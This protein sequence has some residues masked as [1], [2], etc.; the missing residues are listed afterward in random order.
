MGNSSPDNKVGPHELIANG[1]WE[2]ALFTTYALSLTFFET[3][4]LKAGLIRNG[5]QSVWVVSDVEGYQQSLTERQSARVGQEYHLV[6]VAL[7]D[8]VFHPKCIYLSGAG[9]DVLMVGS[10]NLTFG[11]FGRNV[12]VVEVLTAAEHP[13]VFHAFGKYLEALGARKD[14]LNPDPRWIN[15]FSNLAFKA[16]KGVTNSPPEGP[17]LLHCVQ[18]SFADQ[19]AEYFNAAG[20]ASKLR[21]LSPFYDPNADAVRK[22]AAKADCQRIAI[23]LLPGRE[24]QSTFPLF[25]V[26]LDKKTRLEAAVVVT[27]EDGRPLHAKW[28]EAD[29]KDG[30]RLTLTGSVNATNKSMC[31]ADNIEVGLVRLQ[32]AKE[33][34]FLKWETASLPKHFEHRKFT[35]AGLGNR[36]VV[37]AHFTRETLLEGILMG[38]TNPSGQWESYLVRADGE[39]TEF[40]VIVGENGRFRVQVPHAE[41]YATATAVQ[42]VLRRGKQEAAGWLHLE[43]IL[44]LPRL[45][46]LGVTSLM[47]LVNNEQTEED[48]AAL[49]EYLALS[50]QH[51]LLTFKLE[52][53]PRAKTES[54]T[55]QGDGDHN[56]R[57]DLHRLAPATTADTAAESHDALHGSDNYLDVIF[58]RLRRRMLTSL[59][60]HRS[61]GISGA[62]AEETESEDGS[63]TEETETQTKKVTS[64]LVRF[65]EKMRELAAI[66]S[67]QDNLKAVFSMWLEVELLMRVERLKDIEGA[68]FFS[69]NW[70]RNAVQRCRKEAGI[71][72]FDRHIITLA[73]TL[74]ANILGHDTDGEVESRLIQLHEDMERYC[75]GPVSPDFATAALVTEPGL[76][77]SERLRLP[78]AVPLTE[79]LERLLATRTFRQEIGQI[80]SWQAGQPLPDNLQILHTPAGKLLAERMSRTSKLDLV[81]FKAD[82][83]SCPKCHMELHRSVKNELMIYRISQCLN[84]GRFI[85]NRA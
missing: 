15:I 38:L 52:V 60:N 58:G 65:G 35:K 29:L 28:L 64:G 53:K 37:H 22:L 40:A 2:Q 14:F 56:L 7:P 19:L 24:E 34:R 30:S 3:H 71:S 79:A 25:A 4:I 36:W 70:I 8:G 61:R 66:N 78:Q 74:A 68:E 13:G 18:S 76:V 23:G 82:R 57:V 43:A 51:H 33:P 10:G 54:A 26:G 73:A 16:A 41:H 85:I 62:G 47:R 72:T 59:G 32:P 75:E 67:P 46:R 63:E 69:R 11:G 17:H 45:P 80:I 5:C 83:N 84:C 49:L 12:E 20:G 44:N 1:K 6:P 21:I 50:A 42:I 48:D 27:E 77:L 31:T 39:R 9:G 55:R 81:D